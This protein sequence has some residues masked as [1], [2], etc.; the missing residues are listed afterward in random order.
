MKFGR[1]INQR[2]QTVS[3]QHVI[4]VYLDKNLL[5]HIKSIRLKLCYPSFKTNIISIC[6]I[7][8]T[9]QIHWCNVQQIIELLGIHAVQEAGTE[10]THLPE[11]NGSDDVPTAGSLIYKWNIIASRSTR[12]LS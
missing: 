3:E 10:A 8:Y 2:G 5:G 7:C 4:Q 6:I 12:K 11:H 1:P 9:A